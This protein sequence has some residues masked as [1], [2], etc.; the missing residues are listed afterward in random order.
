MRER[1][2]PGIEPDELFSAVSEEVVRQISAKK[3]EPEW[4]LEFRLRALRHF[5]QRPVPTWGA[6]LS[7]LNF[8]EI[9]YYVKPAEMEGKS[10]DEVKKK[11]INK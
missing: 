6:D 4:M 1:G 7:G 5:Q 8:D 9:V 10:W 2:A 11:Y 3:G